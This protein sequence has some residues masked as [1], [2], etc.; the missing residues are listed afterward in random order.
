MCTLH[1]AALSLLLHAARGDPTNET[2]R[3]TKA[4]HKYLHPLGTRPSGPR[5]GGGSEGRRS[6]KAH[7]LVRPRNAA[8]PDLPPAVVISHFCPYS[9]DT[10][11][12]PSRSASWPPATVHSCLLLRRRLRLAPLLRRRT[13]RRCRCRCCSAPPPTGR[14]GWRA[15]SGGWRRSSRRPGWRR[16]PVWAWPPRRPRSPCW[17]SRC[18]RSPW[19]SPRAGR[20]GGA[21][22]SSRWRRSSSACC[23]RR[24]PRP[25]CRSAACPGR[26]PCTASASSSSSTRTSACGSG[27]RRSTSPGSR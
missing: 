12:V 10:G 25:P 4:R 20:A 18:R 22:A 9:G 17:A 7:L 16:R 1:T 2:N 23:C 21:A 5:S 19:R 8:G 11:P 6:Y 27:S 26:W 14:R 3:A 15:G 24:P 13:T